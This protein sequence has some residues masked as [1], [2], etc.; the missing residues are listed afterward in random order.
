M[1]SEI[2]VFVGILLIIL[3][4]Q[5]PDIRLYWSENNMYSNKLYKNCHEARSF[6]DHFEVFTFLR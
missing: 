5:V 2:K 6:L 1:L 4:I 3:I